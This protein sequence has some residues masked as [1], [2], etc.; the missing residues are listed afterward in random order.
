MSLRPT[1]GSTTRCR[2]STSL[3]PTLAYTFCINILKA[4]SSIIAK[5]GGKR[6]EA[7]PRYL[8]ITLEDM[9]LS[10]Y[11]HWGEDSR[12]DAV[13]NARVGEAIFYVI[14][15]EEFGSDIEETMQE[16]RG[17]YKANNEFRVCTYSL[18]DEVNVARGE[19]G[20]GPLEFKDYP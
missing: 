15:G 9:V 19:C 7:K 8:D 16:K 13:N 4:H 17:I 2:L 18:I 10:E 5:E 14:L 6:I 20:L 12:R 3:A 1:S 11:H